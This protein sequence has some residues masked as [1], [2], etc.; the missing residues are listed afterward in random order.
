MDFF[1]PHGHNV[2]SSIAPG[3]IFL[4]VAIETFFNIPS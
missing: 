1:Q 4:T 3:S 2:L